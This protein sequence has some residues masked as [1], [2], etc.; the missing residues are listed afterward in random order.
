MLEP[1]DR[2][3]T[4]DEYRACEDTS[5]APHE[6]RNRYAVAREVPSGAH[7]TISLNLS[8]ALGPL[9]R[10]SGCRA[11]AG[12]AKVVSPS[13]E[14]LI[15]DFVITCDARDREAL[16]RNGEATIASRGSSSRFC[17]RRPRPT[18]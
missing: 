2:R 8:I 17:H 13:G 15:P 11:Y 9:V 14:R 5:A 7:G 18:I 10:V 16:D 1:I 6:Y 12:D 4:L 3:L